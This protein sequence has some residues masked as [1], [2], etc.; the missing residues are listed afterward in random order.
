PGVACYTEQGIPGEIYLSGTAQQE[1]VIQA[2]IAQ[3]PLLGFTPMIVFPTDP[4]GRSYENFL[5]GTDLDPIPFWMTTVSLTPLSQW[6][7][8]F[9]L[10]TLDD[11]TIQ[12]RLMIEDGSHSSWLTINAPGDTIPSC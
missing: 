1:G 12:I 5:T 3:D 4:L 9:D 8:E 6:G 7:T 11:V 2:R 10:L